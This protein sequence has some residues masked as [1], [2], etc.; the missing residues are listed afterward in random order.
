M[1]TLDLRGAVRDHFV[2]MDVNARLNHTRAV[3]NLEMEDQLFEPACFVRAY[4]FQRACLAYAFTSNS[5][6]KLVVAATE[7][8]QNVPKNGLITLLPACIFKIPL[9]PEMG[10]HCTEN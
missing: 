4:E 9:R 2:F 1:P 8:C 10:I 3:D 6:S 5:S 7:E